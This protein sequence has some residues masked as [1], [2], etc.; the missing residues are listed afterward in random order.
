MAGWFESNRATH[1]QPIAKLVAKRVRLLDDRK[2]VRAPKNRLTRIMIDTTA[3]A[4]IKE[5]F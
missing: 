1:R 3:I 2:Q 5:D 4:E